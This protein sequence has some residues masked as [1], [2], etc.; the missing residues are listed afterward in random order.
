MCAKQ[1]RSVLKSVLWIV[2][3]LVGLIVVTTAIG[4][5]LSSNKAASTREVW[6]QS[7]GTWDEFMARHPR[8]EANE[9]ALRIEAL[10]APLGIDLVPKTIEDRP[11]TDQE[12]PASVKKAVA[13]YL[14]RHLERPASSIDPPTGELADWLVAHDEDLAAVRQALLIDEVPRWREHVDELYNAPIPNLIG[15]LAL[16]RLLLAHALAAAAS[17]DPETAAADLEASWMLNGSV[18]DSPI[19]INQLITL[20]AARIQVGVARHVDP[21]PPE[22]SERL[23]S[24]DRRSGLLESLAFE[25]RF[26]IQEDETR[27]ALPDEV[28]TPWYLRAIGAAYWRYCLADWSERWHTLILEME[29]DRHP[30]RPTPDEVGRSFYDSIPTWNVPGR[31]ISPNV[32]NTLDKVRRFELDLELTLKVLQLRAARDA[33]GAWPPSVDGI[34]NSHCPDGRWIYSVA[35]D[36]GISIAFDRETEWPN[37]PGLMLPSQFSA[38]PAVPVDSR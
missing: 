29:D 24:V 23:Q 17:G 4:H 16:H 11:R 38:P 31:I 34:E 30:C 37:Q 3:V 12:Y 1:R 27:T 18:A 5:V 10:A 20:S 33:D 35:D 25:G 32:I 7:H 28:E 2:I 21:L 13:N 6:D 36:G 9:A 15:Q 19:L 14:T 8:R 26:W 22:W